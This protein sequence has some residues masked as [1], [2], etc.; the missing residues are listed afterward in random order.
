MII[1]LANINDYI[2]SAI[3]LTQALGVSVVEYDGQHVILSAPLSP[4]LNHRETAFGGSLSAVAILAGWS[5]LFIKMRELNQS[6][7]LVI[8]H[9]EFDFLKPIDTDFRAHCRLPE[10]IKWQRFLDTFQRKGKARIALETEI[11]FS[12]QQGGQARGDYVAV[13]LEP[14]P[15][16]A[17]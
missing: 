14:E 6:A 11:W 9:S 15:G 12:G 2:H 3:P 4:N 5:L 10:Q 16:E 8:Q 17:Q 1:E 13:R 7:R